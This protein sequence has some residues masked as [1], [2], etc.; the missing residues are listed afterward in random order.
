MPLPD[1]PPAIQLPH[2]ATEFEVAAGAE[3]R[4]QASLLRPRCTAASAGEIVVCASDPK[5]NRLPP[6]SETSQQG[7]SRAEARLNESTTINL[8]VESAP[9]SGAPSNRAMVGVKIGF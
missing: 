9:I 4:T 2:V 3:P 8:H 5:E 6:L 1:A 7:P